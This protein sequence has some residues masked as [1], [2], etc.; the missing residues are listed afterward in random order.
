M[1]FL[2]NPAAAQAAPAT[3]RQRGQAGEDRALRCL[4][5]AGLRLVERNYRTPG[6]GGGEID[7]IMRD[8]DGTLVF[9]EVRSRGRP[10]YGGAGASI[11]AIKQSRIVHAARHYLQ[12]WP[13][14]PPCRFDVVLIEAAG[15]QWLRAAFDSAA[16]PG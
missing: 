10:G 7:L 13:A 14:P 4:Q 15:V 1:G 12:R 2:K 3:T 8:A 6:R 11:G 9:V 5:G 16:L